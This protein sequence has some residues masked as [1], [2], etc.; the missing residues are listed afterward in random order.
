MKSWYEILEVPESA[1]PDQI[2]SAYLRMAREYHPDRVP[3]H[4]TKLRADAEEKFKQIQ[5]AWAVLG[6]PAKRRRYD[7]AGHRQAVEKPAPRSSPQASAK[8]GIRERLRQRQDLI[9]WALLVLITTLVLVL[10]G[11]VF[12]SRTS[13]ANPSATSGEPT[14]AVIATKSSNAH[15]S[16]RRIQTWRAEGGK[17][18]HVELVGI[19]ARSNELEIT[20]R[21]RAGEHSDLLLYEPPG[22]SGR[23]KKILGKD[24]LVD[25]DF[26]ELY[27][28]DETGAKYL[29]TT[30]F[31]GGQQTNFN[32][33]NFTRR[34]NFKPHEEA[35]L[36][37]KFPPPPRGVSSIT[38]VS[39]ALGKW[40]PE[41][42]WPGIKLR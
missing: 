32:L 26:G 10:V 37:A 27:I 29:S 13:P 39:P 5:E 18:L 20:F 15:I 9:K 2:R 11:E 21:L 40:Q 16:P 23:T 12:V 41:W 3:E 25:R 22:G 1:K 31:V 6:D 33:Y 42:L 17:G 36:S 8:Q 24:V 35:V 4:L 38:F 30:G 28:E 34:I 14:P 7:L 19:A